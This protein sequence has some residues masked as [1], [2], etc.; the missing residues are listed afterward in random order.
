[1]KPHH[2]ADPEKGT[3]R[4]D[5]LHVRR[6]HR[7]RLVARAG[8]AGALDPAAERRAAAGDVGRDRAGSRRRGRAR[9]RP[10]IQLANLSAAKARTRIVELLRESG[11]LLG[12][13]RP[14]T[15]AVKFYEKGDRPL[16]ILTSR[17]WF[18]KT[19]DFREALLARGARAA[20]A[21]GR[22]CR[23]GS[24]TGSTA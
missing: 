21:P 13:P 22:T 5:D 18:I 7:R 19:M 2:L 15:H 8:A 1:M 9:S 4:R 10:T 17:Q 11:D 6:R 14:I 12:E 23:R 3:G 24:R 16:E 20:L